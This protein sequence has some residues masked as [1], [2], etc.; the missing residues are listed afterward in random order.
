MEQLIFHIGNIKTGTSS[1]QRFFSDN[2]EQLQHVGAVYPLT[3]DV[4]SRM[5]YFMLQYCNAVVQKS[6]IEQRLPD[7]DENFSRI[8]DAL[9]NDARVLLSDEN[10][11]STC[12]PTIPGEDIHDYSGRKRATWQALAD[13][14]T[15]LGINKVRIVLYLRRQDYALASSWRQITSAGDNRLSLAELNAFPLQVWRHDYASLIKMMLEELGR[16]CEVTLDVRKFSRKEFDGGDIY[17]DFC[18]ATHIPWNDDFVIP[19]AEENPSLTFDVAEAFRSFM[20]V[21]PGASPE[22]DVIMQKAYELSAC[23]PDKPGT[24]PFSEQ[25]A[26]ALMEQYDAGNCWI[27]EHY[28]GG[29]PLFSDEYGNAPVWVPNEDRIEEFKRIFKA[30]LKAYWKHHPG[31]AMRRRVSALRNRIASSNYGTVHA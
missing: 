24:T 6:D 5:G 12:L 25:E 14:F 27:S 18:A 23:Y 7:K 26:R 2:I 4:N 29:E 30:D 8:Q 17:H 11:F 22:H 19:A 10:F 20:D 3:K 9:A 15:I 31:L 21:A 13:V 28:F 16:T 1:L